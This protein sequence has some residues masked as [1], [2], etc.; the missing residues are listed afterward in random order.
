MNPNQN[1]QNTKN[2]S[3]ELPFFAKLVL[4]V[5]LSLIAS[6]VLGF[7]SLPNVIILP[8][9]LPVALIGYKGVK[10][11]LLPYALS[12]GINLFVRLILIDLASHKDSH[13]RN[14]LPGLA[15]RTDL[16]V[17][18]IVAGIS[19]VVAVVA[20][21]V[22][23]YG[24]KATRL[25]SSVLLRFAAVWL[26][27]FSGAT[28]HVIDNYAQQKYQQ[29][30]YHQGL[31]FYQKATLADKL[32]VIMATP[33]TGYSLT[34]TAVKGNGPVY[35]GYELRYTST[36]GLADISAE[37]STTQVPSYCDSTNVP[38]I[39]TDS[40]GQ[41]F[42][43]DIVTTAVNGQPI[44]GYRGLSVLRYQGY[45][46]TKLSTDQIKSVQP[47]IF[48]MV[49]NG[50]LVKLAYGNPNDKESNPL[51]E[52]AVK[53]FAS[54]LTLSTPTER[55]AF[56]N[57]HIKPTKPL[58]FRLNDRENADAAKRSV[59]IALY[60][61]V[62]M[63]AI[64][65]LFK[66]AGKPYWQAYILVVNLWVLTSIAGRPGWWSLLAYLDTNPYS[67]RNVTATILFSPVFLPF[68][69]LLTLIRLVAFLL[70]STSMAENFGKSK[71]FSILLVVPPFPGYLILGFGKS[72]YAPSSITYDIPSPPTLT[73]TQAAL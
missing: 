39:Q 15:H 42:T 27:V 19:A 25:I 23:N 36:K 58:F 8:L 16:Q 29:H 28:A 21:I 22:L 73:E 7:E 32:P 54:S 43:C 26:I 38:R 65:K 18:M 24:F 3:K 37:V 62:F 47:D 51:N 45:D 40:S 71:I 64:E 44:Y 46:P 2:E 48:Y 13:A 67:S 49:S 59:A 56:I 31:A 60:V 68:M 61:A 69:A 11:I 53:G 14:F 10:G 12:V 33:P 66:K 1:V 35:T 41:I 9:L 20:F 17:L 50:A 63:W 34:D 55:Q 57:E 70:I 30:V 4:V 5:L 6:A 72:T 52:A